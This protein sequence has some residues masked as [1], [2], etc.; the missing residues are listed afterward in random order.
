MRLKVWGDNCEG[1]ITACINRSGIKMLR[2]GRLNF[3]WGADTMNRSR[4]RKCSIKYLCVHKDNRS[5]SW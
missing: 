1:Q 2:L 3:D 4:T 5:V